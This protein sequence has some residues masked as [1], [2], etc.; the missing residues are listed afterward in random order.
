[1]SVLKDLKVKYST[2][3]AYDKKT[4]DFIHSLYSI[5]LSDSKDSGLLYPLGSWEDTENSRAA[6]LGFVIALT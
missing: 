1:M 5:R 6:S 3:M 4:I 2:K